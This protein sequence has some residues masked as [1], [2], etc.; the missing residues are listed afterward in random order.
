MSSVD[1][2]PTLEEIKDEFEFLGDWE[3]RCEYLIEL[4]FDLPE[5]SDEAKTEEN[6]VHGARG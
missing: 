4:G 5:F 3:A 1:Q 2:L 6:R